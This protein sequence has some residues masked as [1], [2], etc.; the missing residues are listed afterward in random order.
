MCRKSREKAMSSL[1][2]CG[3]SVRTWNLITSLLHLGNAVA[4]VALRYANDRDLLYEI[5]QS[6][7]DW[8]RD[9]SSDAIIEGEEFSI[10]KKENK[11]IF[12]SCTI[13]NI[14]LH[15]HTTQR[16]DKRIYAFVCSPSRLLPPYW[17][18]CWSHRALH[19][20]PARTPSR[21][22]NPRRQGQSNRV[23]GTSRAW[24]HC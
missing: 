8:S 22:R 13:Y 7:P 18:P 4:I 10:S 17:K 15:T 21:R 24:F 5:K 23:A 16:K 6:Y 3:L 20:P 14:L 1:R 9:T 2:L 19:L 12:L 11:N